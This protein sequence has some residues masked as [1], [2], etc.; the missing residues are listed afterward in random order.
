MDVAHPKCNPSLDYMFG[1]LT[2]ISAGIVDFIAELGCTKIN[3]AWRGVMYDGLCG[4]V[5]DGLYILWICQF[6]TSGMLYF[7]MCVGA[8][9][10][11]QFGHYTEGDGRVYVDDEHVDEYGNAYSGEVEPTVVTQKG[12]YDT[13]AAES[14]HQKAPEMQP[15]QVDAPEMDDPPL[16]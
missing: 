1:N 9:L 13:P 2:V 4:D 16:D 10:Y 7:V 8:V 6:L 11:L 14:Y 5:F 12:D 3:N 15:L